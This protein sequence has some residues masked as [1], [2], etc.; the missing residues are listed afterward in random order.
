MTDLEFSKLPTA[1]QVAVTLGGIIASAVF[2]WLGLRNRVGSQPTAVSREKDDSLADVQRE[3]DQ[4][5]IE[6]ADE[7]VRRDVSLAIEAARV[8]LEHRIENGLT[9]VH[10]RIDAQDDRLR[11]VEIEQARNQGRH[12]K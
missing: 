5:A 10:K 11:D 2:G 8:A 3:R 12:S 1:I 9:E 7:K 6:N 4:L